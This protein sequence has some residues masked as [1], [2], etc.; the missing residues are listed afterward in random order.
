[1]YKRSYLMS[2]HYRKKT[3]SLQALQLPD[4]TAFG[5]R[6]ELTHARLLKAQKKAKQMGEQE[7]YGRFETPEEFAHALSL[8]HSS[9]NEARSAAY[10]IYRYLLPKLEHCEALLDVGIG[11]GRVTRWLA[12]KFI[13]ENNISDIRPDFIHQFVA[14]NKFLSKHT[15]LIASTGNVQRQK[16][17]ENHYDLCVLSHVLYYIDTAH[18]KNIISKLYN[19]L[20]PNGCLFIAMSGYNDPKAK[21]LNYFGHAGAA[22][23]CL[24]DIC[25]KSYFS[26]TIVYESRDQIRSLD[27]LTMTQL[28]G[29]LLND[30]GLRVSKQQLLTFIEHH[31]KRQDG[32][33]LESRQTFFVIRKKADTMC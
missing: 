28:I 8:F 4:F 12:A 1:M 11:D 31:L 13:H 25:E 7:V 14:N 17:T 22:L 32:Y 2:R 5:M 6:D 33:Q 30:V 21:M 19:S 16:F 26:N 3:P 20:K 27:A 9:T 10:F 24:Y 23:P 29:F 15:N 18:W